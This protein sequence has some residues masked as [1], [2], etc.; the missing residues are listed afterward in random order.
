MNISYFRFLE[1]YIMPN[2]IRE[3]PELTHL[4]KLRTASDIQKYLNKLLKLDGSDSL[5]ENVPVKSTTGLS[6]VSE[7]DISK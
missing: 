2:L 1:K 4:V 7:K 3:V 5:S 6:R